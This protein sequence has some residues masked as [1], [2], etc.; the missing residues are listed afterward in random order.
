MNVSPLLPAEVV[1]TVRDLLGSEGDSVR[2]WELLRPLPVDVSIHILRFLWK[3]GAGEADQV[4]SL[5]LGIWRQLLADSHPLD[6]GDVRQALL[7][8]YRG[9]DIW[10]TWPVS[11][12]ELA[13]MDELL[14]RIGHSPEG[15]EYFK[16]IALHPH[17]PR[18]DDIFDEE[19]GGALTCLARY[20]YSRPSGALDVFLAR[21]LDDAPNV[22]YE[23]LVILETMKSRIL[24]TVIPWYMRYD[25][26]LRPILV[27]HQFEPVQDE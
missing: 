19:R 3:E 7:R 12:D 1:A 5:L 15:V 18:L 24:T 17:Y 4:E 9:W 13:Q 10:S 2:I 6:S 25:D 26:A 21:F 11:S 14:D 22:H 8:L 23:V 27:E 16:W 20:A